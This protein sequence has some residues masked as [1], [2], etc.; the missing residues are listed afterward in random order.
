VVPDQGMKRTSMWRLLGTI[1]GVGLVAGSIPVSVEGFDFWEVI[2]NAPIVLVVACGIF[3]LTPCIGCM[4]HIGA[5]LFARAVWWQ[6]LVFSCMFGVQLPFAVEGKGPA[7]MIFVLAFSGSVLSLVSAGR[8]RLEHESGVFKS[9]A[10][11]MALLA[12]FT[13]AMVDAQILL[14]YSGLSAQYILEGDSTWDL[15][16]FVKSTI[17][18]AAMVTALVGMYR[19]KVWAVALN[20]IVNL[21]IAAYA[22]CGGVGPPEALPYW[23]AAI[24]FL[25]LLV[26]IPMIRFILRSSKR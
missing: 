9:V 10:F 4:P 6:A 20:V 5:Q 21:A 23:F 3:M 7:V 14:L 8:M 15:V 13:L 2:N 1:V 17:A 22:L 24:A 12:S 11:R 26:S 25:Q 19:L 18:S 16:D